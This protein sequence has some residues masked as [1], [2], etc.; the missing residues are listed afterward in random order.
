MA[1]SKGSESHTGRNLAIAGGGLVAAGIAAGLVVPRLLQA[2]AERPDL[3][4]AWNYK[5]FEPSA[6]R[7]TVDLS[8]YGDKS[9][10]HHLAVLAVD[11]GLL[12]EHLSRTEGLPALAVRGDD[13]RW[14]AG[15]VT[16]GSFGEITSGPNRR[17]AVLVPAGH[18]ALHAVQL[19]VMD[20]EQ[21]VPFDTVAVD[22]SSARDIRREYPDVPLLGVPPIEFGLTPVSE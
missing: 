1:R 19:G 16:N 8:V 6:E 14:Y 22:A 3:N 4:L 9:Y 10:K 5:P 20:E 11:G 21:Y 13:D 2:R 15:V 18:T 12:D 7:G 17:R